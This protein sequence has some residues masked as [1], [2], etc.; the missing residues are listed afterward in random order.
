MLVGL[1]RARDLELQVVD[2]T[3][4]PV[5]PS[6][7]LVSGELASLM[8]DPAAHATVLL[9]VCNAGHL[10]TVT[11]C[12]AHRNTTQQQRALWDDNV[13]CKLLWLLL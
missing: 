7:A 1:A 9:L 2:A 11:A 10:S 3:G 13:I 12:Q 4:L 6:C 8:A 5:L